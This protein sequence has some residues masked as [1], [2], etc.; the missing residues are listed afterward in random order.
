MQD[1]ATI[2]FETAN[3]R[4][5]SFCAVGVVIIRDS[6]I[7]DKFYPL[8]EPTPNCYTCWI[9]EVNGMTRRDTLKRITNRC[10]L[11]GGIRANFAV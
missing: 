1:F 2:D 7:V 6:R 4:R 9:T 8:I 3:G 11:R 10:K 5:C